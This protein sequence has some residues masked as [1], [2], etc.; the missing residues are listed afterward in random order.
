MR[1]ADGTYVWWHD[2]GTAQRDPTGKAVIMSG[3]CIDITEKKRSEAALR[4]SEDRFRRIMEQSPFSV[5]VIFS[6]R[7]SYLAKQCILQLWGVKK[8]AMEATTS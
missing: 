8:E 2:I 7:K 6:R 1:K 3:A 5:Q 4:K